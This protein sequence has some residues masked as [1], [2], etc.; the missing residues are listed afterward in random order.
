MEFDGLKT[1]IHLEDLNY[2]KIN[3]DIGSC[4]FNKHS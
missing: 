4:R 3:N 2:A 1:N